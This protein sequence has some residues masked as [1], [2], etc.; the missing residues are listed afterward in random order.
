MISRIIAILVLL[1]QPVMVCAPA[2]S[3]SCLSGETESICQAVGQ[4]TCCCSGDAEGA[5]LDMAV[6]PCA[7]PSN[8][9]PTAPAPLPTTSS[10]KSLLA[11]APAPAFVLIA[12][13]HVT[14]VLFSGRDAASHF[15]TNHQQRSLLC[16]WLT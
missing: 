5:S 13:T 6:C 1:L 8:R 9:S 15:T 12:P 16:V 3:A 11:T 10:I 7:G 14:P 2:L 4:G